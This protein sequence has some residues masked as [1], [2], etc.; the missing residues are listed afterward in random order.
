[1]KITNVADDINVWYKANV[2]NDA[3]TEGETTIALE[4]DYSN[5]VDFGKTIINDETVFDDHFAKT[6]GNLVDKVGKTEFIT[7]EHTS[8]APNVWKDGDSWSTMRELVY[9]DTEDASESHVFDCLE[10]NRA[11]ENPSVQTFEEMFNT[12]APKV[13]ADYYNTTLTFKDKYTEFY[14]QMKNAFKSPDDLNKFVTACTV[15]RNQKFA[16]WKDSV[17]YMLLDALALELASENNAPRVIALQTD[18]T[19]KLDAKS[20]TQLNDLIDDLALYTNVYST[21]ETST[22]STKLE[23]CI[24]SHMFNEYKASLAD[25]YNPEMLNIPFTRLKRLPYF[26]YRSNPQ[27]ITGIAPSTPN[28]KRIQIDNVVAVIYHPL[29]IGLHGESDN[30]DFQR[31][32]NE[33]VNYFRNYSAC[34]IV[35]K[36]MPAIIITLN[37][38][39]DITEVPLTN[40]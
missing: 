30:T 5:I 35:N 11:S 9:V 28:G 22:D 14:S 6:W 2:K 8:V 29:A 27:R 40:E 19:G 34:G 26:Q 20:I 7:G 33:G 3:L 12:V 17:S 16:V 21:F 39:Q 25:T 31:V 15:K 18:S 1:M 32:V 4:K 38:A 10:G 23:V 37:G 13:K 24:N 36:N